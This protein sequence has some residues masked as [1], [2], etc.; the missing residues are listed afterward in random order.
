[1]LRPESAESAQP[2]NG[3][4]EELLAGNSDS[5]AGAMPELTVDLRVRSSLIEHYMPIVQPIARRLW[6]VSMTAEDLSQEGCIGLMRAA[7]KYDPE[8]GVQFTTFAR[9]YVRGTILSSIRDRDRII[10]GPRGD[11][12]RYLM[13]DEAF[14]ALQSLGQAITTQ[15]ISS[16]SGLSLKD[17]ANERRYRSEQLQFRP[18]S[19]DAALPGDE[20]DAALADLVVDEV[21]QYE[22]LIERQTAEVEK[23]A[24][25]QSLAKMRNQKYADILRLRFGIEPYE[26]EYTQEEIADVVG[27]SQM[28]ISR[29]IPKALNELRRLLMADGRIDR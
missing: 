9:R 2:V 11:K 15:S 8:F 1:M 7:D 6:G 20:S 25:R 12:A 18:L 3:D 16:T 5:L 28:H 29:L 10:T 19:L 24:I 21:D 27:Y 26:K 4:S 17:I 13:Y 23:E 22:L 14:I